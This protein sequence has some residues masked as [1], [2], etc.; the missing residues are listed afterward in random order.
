[1]SLHITTDNFFVR[2]ASLLSAVALAIG[3]FLGVPAAWADEKVEKSE[4]PKLTDMQLPSADELLRADDRNGKAFDWIVLKAS[5]EADRT[6]LVVSPLEI[7][8]DTLKTM[9]ETY[10]K[11]E[12]TKPK[13][14]EERTERSTRLKNLKQL[15]V[16]LPGNA[17][18]EYALPVSSID[19]IILFEEIMLRRADE[20][21]KEGDIRKA[22]E[23]MLRVEKE[24]PSW[25]LSKPRFENLLLVESGIRAKDG[26]IYAALA[27]L[28]ELA[29][30]NIDNPELRPRFGEIVAPMIETAVAD[31]DFNKARYLISGIER[32]FPGHETSTLWQGRMQ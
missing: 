1:M 10:V 28:D 25:E 31:E 2:T 15:I 32:V 6:V 30:R 14:E 4:L 26:D 29:N 21:L 5:V 27:L 16:K 17:V 9:A 19:H 24:F 8:P 22:Y 3:L 18:A 23:L 7:R 11:V 13:N 12:A 20:L